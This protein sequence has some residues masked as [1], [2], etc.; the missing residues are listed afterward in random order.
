MAVI[1]KA[2]RADD[3]GYILVETHLVDVQLGGGKVVE[4]EEGLGAGDDDVV[5]GHGH[6]V[7]ANG[8][9]F[10]H[11]EGQFEL[12]SDSIRARDQVV[13]AWVKKLGK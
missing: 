7:N 1:E 9:M 13:I 2:I 12:S 8:V 11:L 6:Q 10:V 4:E 5:N 3:W